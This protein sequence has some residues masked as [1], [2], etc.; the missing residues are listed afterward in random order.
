M[1]YSELD[2]RRFEVRKVEVYR[3]GH[4]GYASASEEVGGTM[5]GLVPIP[6]LDEIADDP[7]FEPV[8]I[9]A[10]EFEEV[11]SKRKAK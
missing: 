6:K 10:V 7:A 9:N 4:A 1:L 2:D 3:D 5:L 11:W 8:E